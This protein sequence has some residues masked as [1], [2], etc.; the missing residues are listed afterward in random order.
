MDY[1]QQ[2]PIE[3]CGGNFMHHVL[4]PLTKER[5]KSDIILE[6]NHFLVAI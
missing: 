1:I 5:P 6:Y 4:E 3:A 2:I